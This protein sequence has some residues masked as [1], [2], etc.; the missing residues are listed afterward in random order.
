MKMMLLSLG[1]AMSADPLDIALAG[2]RGN[3][4]D[5]T[6]TQKYI[7]FGAP[8]TLDETKFT[9]YGRWSVNSWHMLCDWVNGARG[10]IDV[11]GVKHKLKI[12]YANDHSAGATG[13]AVA[14]HMIDTLKVDFMLGPYSSGST[15]TVT[16]ATESRKIIVAA[17]G[18]AATS[19][20]AG[21]KYLFG[22]FVPSSTYMNP[23]LEILAEKSGTKLKVGYFSEDAS[24]TKGV[25]SGVTNHA[26]AAGLELDPE[27]LIVVPKSPSAEELEGVIAKFVERK[28][29][30]VFGCTYYKTCTDFV[31]TAKK[32]DFNP[33]AITLGACVDSSQFLL[34]LGDD[35]RYIMGPA[36]WFKKQGGRAAENLNNMTSTEWDAMQNKKFK[37]S[38]PY[39]GASAY[40]AP[41]VLIDAIEKA[42]SIDSDAVM[43]VLRSKTFSSKTFYG[44]VK[45]DDN[46]QNAA[47]SVII[48]HN[49]DSEP[50][51][52][53]PH[54]EKTDNILFPTPTWKYRACAK[55]RTVSTNTGDKTVDGCSSHGQCQDDGTCICSGEY[56]GENC[57]SLPE[58][59]KV[60][61]QTKI[62]TKLGG[63]VFMAMLA[64][65]AV[66]G[67]IIIS[68]MVYYK[69]NGKKY[70]ILRASSVTFLQLIL[71]SHLL[72]FAAAISYTVEANDMI[73][74]IRPWL[75]T[76]SLIG[77]LSPLFAKTSR[78]YR[79]FN[80]T[81]MKK[82]KITDGDLFKQ[83]GVHL[84]INCVLLA[85]WFAASRPEWEQAKTKDD[86]TV[87]SEKIMSADK[88]YYTVTTEN[89][90]HWH[91]GC[92]EGD[93][94]MVQVLIAYFVVLVG[95]GCY[96]C[97]K[98]TGLPSEF[99]ESRSIAQINYF[100]V[101]FGTLIIVIQFLI[102]A[103]IDAL[104]LVRGFGIM[105]G[106]ITVFGIL[107]GPKIAAI[108]SGAGNAKSA[109]N[110]TKATAG[111]TSNNSSGNTGGRN[112]Q[113]EPLVSAKD[114]EAKT[115]EIASLKEKIAKLEATAAK[116][117]QK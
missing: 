19:K 31:K 46:M 60:S 29:D 115:K 98:T 58:V 104:A 112:N 83:I 78:L 30:V 74:S 35:G 8:I 21:K 97:Y 1:L 40:A 45:F 67:L 85:V 11:G 34:D 89:F 33:K 90:H 65:C 114:L 66:F 43:A 22:T 117:L 14:E 82:M 87:V 84:G 94:M 12:S 2:S 51:V 99:N 73:C 7:H 103:N 4:D 6:S 69:I 59:K 27:G 17:G 32:L 39:Q 62:Q 52:V 105:L 88:E 37:E 54:A 9:N 56:I 38:P 72:G 3:F 20:F 16:E 80:N 63:G 116:Q 76:C 50:N 24:F 113:V 26:A 110:Q 68:L 75:L 53:Y 79:L 107:H 70:S 49:G 86:H 108:R 109:A 18:A 42:G 92:T 111:A 77:V 61:K 81:K 28:V 93:N 100:I 96:M 48:Q 71:F 44:T 102:P 25:C 95:Y 106:H 36:P 101:T 23:A 5:A 10:G 55:P 64:F 15:G 41:L 47:Q 91:N 13:K 57:A